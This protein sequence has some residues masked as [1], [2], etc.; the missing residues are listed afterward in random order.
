[1][2]QKALRADDRRFPP[3]ALA[4][5]LGTTFL[6]GA[7]AASGGWSALA[8]LPA[9]AGTVWLSRLA[10]LGSAIDG[11]PWGP[12]S[13]ALV[14][15]V[16]DLLAASILLSGLGQLDRMPV[17][18]AWLRRMRLRAMRTLLKYPGLERTALFGVALLVFIPIP[19]SGSAIG[20]LI[21]QVV[22]LTRTATLGTVAVGSGLSVIALAATARFLDERWEDIA[23]SPWAA[24]GSL[25]T[26]GAFAWIAWRRVRRQLRQA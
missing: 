24:L 9:V 11:N 14:A 21:G 10:I 16:L 17:S 15:W 8:R 2:P 13:L 23:Q 18:G 4:V 5:L 12:W 1:M 25:G 26:I 3:L 6:V 20:T 7:H 19:G 22:G